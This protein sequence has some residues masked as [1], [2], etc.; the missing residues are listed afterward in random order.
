VRIYNSLTRRA[1]E[2]PEAPAEIGLY[3][4]G[5]TP[6]DSPHLGHARAAV[7]F[8]AFVRY[9]RHRG[10][11]VK[12]VRNITDVDDK[13]INRAGIDF[14]PLVEKYVAEYR[15]M[16]EKLSCVPPDLEPRVSDHIP[17]I[18]AL[19]ER[20]I[21]TGHAY[22]AGGSVYFA[23]RTFPTYGALSGRN[24]D[25]L[26][27]GARVEPG[28]EKHDPLDF[29][30]WKQA[31]PGEP[32]WPSPW[33]DG[34]PGWHIECSAMSMKYLG[35]TFAI[36]GGGIDLVFPHHENERA[37]SMAATGKELA[38]IWMHNGLVMINNTK[39][40]KS[41]GNA[42]NIHKLVETFG[43]DV[44]RFFILA[45]H[46]ASPLDFSE[47]RVR[48]AARGLARFAVFADAAG[49][50]CA[51]EPGPVTAEFLAALDENFNTARALSVLF[52]AVKEGNRRG[53][54]ERQRLVAELKACGAI[55][56]LV[57]FPEK[58]G[59]AEIDRLVAERVAARKNR[60][61]ARA[62][63]IRNQLASM[64]IIVEDTATGARWRISVQ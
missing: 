58:Q 27:A 61:F 20:L 33:G 14:R 57:L 16:T 7:V 11:A 31:K 12:V 26:Q 5:I 52:D 2:L 49:D 3:V 25:E 47:E 53:G 13:I 10:R 59:D 41:L 34:R 9:L 40:A 24:L 32:S 43:G 42:A 56:G 8:D 51:A 23:V 19:T 39:M 15:A 21:A 54:E 38:L 37:Q 45:T 50:E 29:A 17:E 63:E 55:L 48:E 36:H 1:D 18:I 62:D 30:L 6:Y 44:L 64:N 35:E 28:E 60:D 22:V 46:F 4:C